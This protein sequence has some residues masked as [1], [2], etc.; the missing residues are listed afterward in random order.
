MTNTPLRPLPPA[1]DPQHLSA[2]RGKVHCLRYGIVRAHVA[3][4]WRADFGH[5][6][7]PDVCPPALPLCPLAPIPL[8]A[9]IETAIR[10]MDR[11][12]GQQLDGRT[13]AIE[14]VQVGGCLIGL[15]VAC[16]ACRAPGC[17]CH[18]CSALEELEPW[19]MLVVHAHR[20]SGRFVSRFG[21]TGVLR[22]RQHSCRSAWQLSKRIACS[23]SCLSLKLRALHAKQPSSS[24]V[25][26][27]P[28]ITTPDT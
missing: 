13:I 1:P 26:C 18:S 20:G 28:L 22:S 11:A 24:H 6:C 8:V 16:Q 27:S 9:D 21:V 10:A 12:N 15:A 14:Y 25:H 5:Q 7:G 3:N 23:G 2:S 19:G 17:S 4:A